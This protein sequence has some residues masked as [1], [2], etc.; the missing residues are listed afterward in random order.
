MWQNRKSLLWVSNAPFNESLSWIYNSSLHFLFRQSAAYRKIK[1]FVPEFD[2]CFQLPYALFSS[3]RKYL[4][5]RAKFYESKSSPDDSI[6]NFFGLL[7]IF[8]SR[9]DF[10]DFVEIEFDFN[11][12][13]ERI[14][15]LVTPNPSNKSF[16][17]FHHFNSFSW[18]CDCLISSDSAMCFTFIKFFFRRIHPGDLETK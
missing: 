10:R 8:S 17:S 12:E 5:T 15:K 6:K 1:R 16:K 18:I 11:G 9:K 13:R 3:E 4:W 14:E 7:F 2:A